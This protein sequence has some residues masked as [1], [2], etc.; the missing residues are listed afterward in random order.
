MKLHEIIDVMLDVDKEHLS[1]EYDQIS[2]YK[3]SLYS[4][5][6]D[7]FCCE[8]VCMVTSVTNNS[9][10]MRIVPSDEFSE[11]VENWINDTSDEDDTN[12]DMEAH[13]GHIYH[14]SLM[15]SDLL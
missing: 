8:P 1:V 6:S 13:K 2:K 5:F 12:E 3:R 10:Y 4:Y 15:F 9:A 14:S 7:Y 11:C